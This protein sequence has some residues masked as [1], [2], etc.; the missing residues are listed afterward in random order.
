M[1][2][3]IRFIMQSKKNDIFAMHIMQDGYCVKTF[4]RFDN[5]LCNAWNVLCRRFISHSIPRIYDPNLKDYKGIYI[6]FD[7]L[8]E[9]VDLAWLKKNNPVARLILVVWNPVSR[10][11]LDLD[12]ARQMGYEVWSYGKQCAQYHM[13]ENL[14]FYCESMYEKALQTDA[15]TQYDIIFAG[16]DKGR[17]DKIKELI[18]QNGWQKLKWNLYFTPDHFWQIFKKKE[19]RRTL[20]YED[21][22][23]MQANARAIM[24]LM[25]APDADITMRT[26]DSLI[27]KRK[28]I[29]DAK[30]IKER[31]YYNPNNV[32]VIGDDPA[33]ALEEFLNKQYVPISEDIVKRYTLD[34]WVKRIVN[35]T[36]VN[37]WRD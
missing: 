10:I 15:R 12:A 4:Q 6:V 3:K 29:T 13:K 30:E 9:M 27:L 21:V 31:D 16:K 32:F 35:D 34:E 23:A 11:K 7:G 8:V 26:L 28:L 20:D 37:E 5:L 36:P 24:E 1:K 17:M 18:N 25:P 22:Q 19:Y 14:Y 2:N 33:D